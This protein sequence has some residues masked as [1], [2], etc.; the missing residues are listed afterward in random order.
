MKLFMMSPD[1]GRKVKYESKEEEGLIEKERGMR[2]ESHS[3]GVIGTAQVSDRS[4]KVD[5]GTKRG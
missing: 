3:C 1:M 4:V 2:L 5:G